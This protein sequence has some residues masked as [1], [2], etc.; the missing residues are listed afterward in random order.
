MMLSS[1]RQQ[2]TAFADRVHSLLYDIEEDGGVRTLLAVWCSVIEWVF[3][4]VLLLGEG[5]SFGFR[6]PKQDSVALAFR[7]G[8]HD[9][10][11]LPCLSLQK[12]QPKNLRLCR[13]GYV[14]EIDR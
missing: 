13:F 2:P 1:Q 9:N 4:V 8:R 11:L 6:G 3:V 14:I 5:R 12:A 10:A 7:R